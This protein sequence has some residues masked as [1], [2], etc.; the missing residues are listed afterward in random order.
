MAHAE[1]PQF[2]QPVPAN[3]TIRT[4][5]GKQY[6]CWTDRLGKAVK[7]LILSSGKCRRTV[8]GKWI[9]CYRD[10]YGKKC[11]TQTFGD[12]SHALQTAIQLEKNAKAVK[13]GRELP[14]RP[15]GKLLLIDVVPD[16]LSQLQ[17]EGTGPKRIADAK[18]TLERVIREHRLTTIGLVDAE[19][20]AGQLEKD[21]LAGRGEGHPPYSIRTRNYWTVTL[22]AFGAWMEN[23]DRAD[24]NPFRRLPTANAEE[25][26]RRVRVPMQVEHLPYLIDAARTSAKTIQH[27]TGPDRA[28]LYLLGAFTGLRAGALLRLTP[29][30]FTWHAGEP[31]AVYSSARLQKNREAHGVPLVQH[32][33]AELAAWLMTRPPGQPLFPVS[34]HR[35]T[36]EML[37]RDLATARAVWIAEG[38][39][40]AERA[41]RE[42]SDVLKPTNAAGE[43]FDFHTLRIQTGSMLA[44]AGVPLVITQKILDHSDPKLT[45]NIYSRFGGE[46]AAEMAKL[47]SLG[48]SLG[49]TTFR[50]TPPVGKSV[51]KRTP[52]AKQE[53]PRK[54]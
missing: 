31:V 17:R 20:L 26:R 46:L 45:A 42:A 16:Y 48:A 22:R 37:H 18:Y 54:A 24:R 52:V 10:H 30:S 6:A 5:D 21:R 36:A 41:T 32:I 8:P 27:L 13:E 43:V 38:K 14:D 40:K 28:A 29:E 44:A 9:G 19:K 4:I 11:K 51:N 53:T 12:R 25:D 35:R 47:P 34:P 3:A 1:R 33:R 50:Q 2:T 49:A 7:A 39:T 23:T 15:K